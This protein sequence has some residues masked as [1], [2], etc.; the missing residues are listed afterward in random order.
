MQ[1][2]AGVVSSGEV[3]EVAA[4]AEALA[5][6]G[7]QHGPDVGVGGRPLGRLAQ[8]DGQVHGDRVGRRGP[9]ELDAGDAGHHVQG[10]RLL[11]HQTLRKSAARA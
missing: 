8:R 9:V 2:S 7:E 1:V 5:G 10:D 3:A 4:G 6:A 11:S